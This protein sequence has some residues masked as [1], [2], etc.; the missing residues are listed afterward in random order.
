MIPYGAAVYP[1]VSMHVRYVKK[2][3]L[4]DVGIEVRRRYGD[5]LNSKNTAVPISTPAGCSLALVAVVIRVSINR[6]LLS[7]REVFLVQLLLGV[8]KSFLGS[9]AFGLHPTRCVGLVQLSRILVRV[10]GL[11]GSVTMI[12]RGVPLSA[13]PRTLLAD[14]KRYR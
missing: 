5:F 11:S 14:S 13:K 6:Q 1:V 10:A 9:H 7:C 12:T 4:R 8:G 2:L 3:P